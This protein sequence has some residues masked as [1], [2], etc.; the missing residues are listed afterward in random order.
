MTIH[1]QAAAVPDVDYRAAFDASRI[2]MA[3]TCLATG[4]ILDVNPAWSRATGLCREDAVAAA[5]A[6]LVIGADAAQHAACLAELQE[7]GWV[8]A[9]QV[10]L[11]TGNGSLA[12]GV[13]ARVLDGH[14]GSEQKVLWEILDAG[15]PP[16]PAGDALANSSDWHRSLLQYTFDGICIFDD[17]K[18]VLEVNERFAAMLGYSPSEM[19]GMHPWDWDTE[20]HEADLDTRYPP[21]AA[22]GYTMETRHRRKDGTVYDAEVTL[23]H[24]R[25]GDRNVAICVTRDITERK[26]SETDLREARLVRDTIQAAIPGVSYALDTSGRFRFWSASFEEATG[27]SAAELAQCNAVDLFENEDKALVAQRIMEVFTQ[28]QSQVEAV[29]VARDGRRTP[30]YFTGRRILLGGEPILVGAAVDISARKAAEASLWALNEELEARVQRNTADLKASYAKL[31]DTEFAMESVGIGIHWVDSSN[32]RFLHVNRFAATLLGYSPEELLQRT[33]SDIDP[34][35]PLPAFH[36]IAERI[37]TQGFLKFET[38]QLRRDGSLVPVDMTV[39]HQ[40]AGDGAPPRLISFLQ[41]ITERKRADQAL[42]EAKEAAEAANIA[43][44]SFLANMSHE[45]RTP[46]NA[47]L[48]L[49]HLMQAGPLLAQQSDR[50]RKMEVASRHLL[51]IINDILDLSKIEAGRLEIDTDNFHLSAVIDNVASIIRESARGKGLHLE[52]D[53]NGV[54]LWLHGDVTRLRQSLLNLAGNAV[55]FTEQG[56]IAIRARLMEQRGDTLQV[57]FEVQDSGIGM[58]PEQQARLFGNF[59]QAD[60]STARKYGGTGLG[61]ALTKRLVE[62]MGGE[63]GVQSAPGRG[64]TFWFTVALQVGHGPV[65]VQNMEESIQAAESRLRKQ[66]QG[67]R[68]L[69][70]EDNP[71]NAE[72]ITEIVHATGMD[73][74]VAGNGRIALEMAGR[75]HYDLILMDMQM[76]EMDGIEATQALRR[77]SAHALT[78]ILAL[79]ANAFAEDR[80]AC[81]AA[82]MNDVLTKPI[83]PALLYRALA[84]WLPPGTAPVAGQAR[85]VDAATLS[86]LDLLRGVPGIDV[87]GGLRFMNGRSDRYQ[88]MLGQFA[89]SRGSDVASLEQLLA[90]GDHVAAGRLAHSLKGAAGTLGLTAIA[91]LATRIDARLNEAGVSGTH[92]DEILALCGEL[93]AAWTALNQALQRAGLFV[94]ATG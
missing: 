57:R 33:V 69:L 61:L 93:G 91:D 13:S 18:A 79:T 20:H 24:A 3:I 34:N 32:A 36:E 52:V 76:P 50:L 19:V 71:I 44:S 83:E 55:K 22:N 45:I 48:G 78:P 89:A 26:R 56:S 31:R 65:P 85:Q 64:S 70:A 51:S 67:I 62:M 60:S 68:I 21:N 35:F 25:I 43:K 84:R 58:T 39:Y 15:V 87:D 6:T 77:L 38:E 9:C 81:L 54:P 86:P 59:Q 5:T 47:I 49:N 82:G 73:I 40:P 4:R 92:T 8:A 53:P 42:R 37:R 88:K 1:T 11:S 66:Y 16:S 2:G 28:G 30:Y 14:G 29:L 72:V 12:H 74:A 94:A 41:D 27:R 23:R 75:Q 7:Q 80:R 63:V 90:A 10:R 46:L 17:A